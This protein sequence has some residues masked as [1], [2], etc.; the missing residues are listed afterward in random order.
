M[1]KYSPDPFDSP[2]AEVF[3]KVPGFEAIPFEKIELYVNELRLSLP[4]HPFG[5]TTSEWHRP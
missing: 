3:K 1:R 2:E 5:H 4:A